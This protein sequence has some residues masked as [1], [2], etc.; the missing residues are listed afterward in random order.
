LAGASLRAATTASGPNISL[1]TSSPTFATIAAACSCEIE[2][3][4]RAILFA[5]LR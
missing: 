2:L 4:Q 3:P 5:A 1:W